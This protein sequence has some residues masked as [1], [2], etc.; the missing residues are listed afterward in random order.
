[1]YTVIQHAA[2]VNERTV[3]LGCVVLKGKYIEA[4]LYDNPPKEELVKRYG[5]SSFLYRLRVRTLSRV[6]L[7]TRYISGSPD[8]RK[9]ATWRQK[10]GLL[11]WAVS[12]VSLTC[13]ITY[14]RNNG[15]GSERQIHT[16]CRKHVYP[17]RLLHGSDQHQRKGSACR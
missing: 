8:N 14:P 3:R 1:M 12:P 6:S 17:L 9:K 2:V 15:S 10:A 11:F 16:G 4:V 7:T 13:P 5:A